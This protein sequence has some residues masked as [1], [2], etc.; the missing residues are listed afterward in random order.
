MS[1]VVFGPR[2]D[3]KAVSASFLYALRHWSIDMPSLPNMM[4]ITLSA[5]AWSQGTVSLV[6]YKLPSL[7][8]LWTHNADACKMG[9]EF[10]VYRPC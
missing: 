5:L 4:A 7:D 1:S 6:V 8:Q 10:R 3:T 2:F 9:S